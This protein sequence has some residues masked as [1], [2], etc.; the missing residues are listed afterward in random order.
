MKKNIL[1][2]LVLLT[3]LSMSTGFI[4][5]RMG[6]IMY[7]KVNAKDLPEHGLII[8]RP[9]DPSFDS[10]AA[11][12]LKGKPSDE[13]ESLK[14]FSALIKNEGDRTVVAYTLVWE[15]TGVD[16][17]K[18]TYRKVSANSEAL[19]EGQD[20]FDALARTDINPTIKPNSTRLFSLF[21]PL[22]GGG[23]GGSSLSREQ[24]QSAGSQLATKYSDITVSIDGAF[25]DD[26]TFVGPDTTG[27]FDKIQI[28]VNAK[29]DVV[30]AIA[31]K[32]K[33]KKSDDEVFK[34]VEVKAN[35]KG[36][37]FLDER[38]TLTDR[39]NHY[40][41]S[42]ATQLLQMRRIYGDKKAIAIALRSAGKPRLKLKKK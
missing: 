12:L 3:V 24:I 4:W 27:F 20:F 33:L 34:D 14:P 25:F 28:Q 17:K 23:G 26:G 40:S 42:F 7:L 8:I 6:R 32:V 11:E 21:Q 15:L 31:E 38:A 22:S 18:T 16:G 19:T 2:A 30:A 13:V 36:K 5:N 39:Y 1:G 29:L 10:I 37:H 35:Y 9:S 41:K